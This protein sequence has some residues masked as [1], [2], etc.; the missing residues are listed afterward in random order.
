MR[1]NE[2][3][4]RNRNKSRKRYEKDNNDKKTISILSKSVI[5]LLIVFIIV[6]VF[7]GIYNYFT[8]KNFIASLRNETVETASDSS[9]DEVKEEEP[10]DITFSLGAIGDIMC[11]NTQYKDAYNSET[12]EYDFSYVFDD[13]NIYTKVADLCVGNLETTFAGE[14]R[15]YSSYPT[16]N[17]PDSLAYNLKKLG[18]DVLTTANNHSL[19]TGFSGLSRTIDILND[20]DIPHL[21]TYTS[22]EQ[23]DTVFIKYIKGI[24]IAF[25]NY[26]YGTNGI[27][28]PS[29]KP[30]AVNLIDKDL[31]AND[32]QSAKD[33]GAEIIIACMHW[34]TEYQTSPN[35][36]Q[37]ELA[38]FLFQNGVNII[39][40][41]HPHVLQPMEKR[42]VTLEDG[43][44][45]DG[46][47][48]YSLGNF[49]A[50]QN[51]K[52]TRSSI[53]LDLTIT[54]HVDGSVT[55]DHAEYTPI[56][57]LKD[58]SK[59]TQKF[60]IL[61]IE[62]SIVEYESDPA[63]SSISASTYNTI[64]KELENIKKIVGEEF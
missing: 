40:G 52:N 38:D 17:T 27:P 36:E 51:A 47:V 24:K 28:V 32:I 39:L 26:T 5:I 4:I 37:E 41:G 7:Y 48:I 20:A 13:I 55:I 63:N 42:T 61:D 62:K 9:S 33:E 23:K 60:K 29:D 53:I 10:T 56:Y 8:N 57:M 22:Q 1:R 31:I 25:V 30:Y 58:T 16:F 21:G 11:H 59:Q 49:T 6:A 45:R 3:N 15:G 54:K 19:D 43:T 46:F 14:D 2:R 18:L 12:G 64:T 44:T 34:G 35:S 50:D